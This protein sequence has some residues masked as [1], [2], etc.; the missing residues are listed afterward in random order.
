MKKDTNAI[1][2]VATVTGSVIGVGLAYVINSIA[3]WTP[4][5]S[6]YFPE[7][8]FFLPFIVLGIVA[9]L[10]LIRKPLSRSDALT[11]FLNFGGPFFT[12]YVVTTI[13]YWLVRV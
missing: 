13:L 2:L 8:I 5:P 10:L 11:F 9:V 12:L 7:M 3:D 1:R 4:W 6:P